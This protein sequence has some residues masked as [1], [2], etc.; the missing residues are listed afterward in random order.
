MLTLVPFGI[1]HNPSASWGRWKTDGSVRALPLFS[2]DVTR[3]YDLS[4]EAA[5]V[6]TGVTSWSNYQGSYVETVCYMVPAILQ[7]DVHIENDTIALASEPAEAHVVRLAN[8]T[9]PIDV[10]AA[11]IRTAQNDTMDGITAA[12]SVLT[13]AN[14]K[15]LRKAHIGT[16]PRQ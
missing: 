12:V 7:Y 9:R 14:G 5:L 6:T 15:Q 4:S 11:A 13:S 1:Q 2:V 3:N 10:R 8:N 16:C